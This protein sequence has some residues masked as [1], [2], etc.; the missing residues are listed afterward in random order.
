MQQ[1][2]NAFSKINAILIVVVVVLVGGLVGLVLTSLRREREMN[3]LS[4]RE[5]ASNTVKMASNEVPI[6]QGTFGITDM[7][8]EPRTPILW[9]NR[10][11]TGVMLV[12]VSNNFHEQSIPAGKSFSYAFERP[13]E[14]FFTIKRYEG[15]LRVVVK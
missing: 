12:S 14:Y 13:G 1:Q 4:A 8:I 11:Q 5:P 7:Q 15:I 6:I 2:E 10:G 3:V 9:S